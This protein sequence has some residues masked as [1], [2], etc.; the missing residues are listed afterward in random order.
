LKVWPF[1][2][3]SLTLYHIISFFVEPVVREGF[4]LLFVFFLTTK[5]MNSSLF[6][7]LS[8]PKFNTLAIGGFTLPI[9]G[10]FTLR[11]FGGAKL[12]ITE[13]T[14]ATGDVTR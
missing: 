11:N 7:A 14:G 6:C 9:S 5:V 10:G 1:E 12:L 8:Y 3:N 2:N 13:G 4:I